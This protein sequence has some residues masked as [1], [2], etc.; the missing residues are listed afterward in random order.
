[1]PIAHK[2]WAFPRVGPEL[3]AGRWQSHFLSGPPGIRA[4]PALPRQ[5]Q[6]HV[7]RTYQFFRTG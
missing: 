3:R 5:S 1:M 4:L 6:N 2:I 7:S